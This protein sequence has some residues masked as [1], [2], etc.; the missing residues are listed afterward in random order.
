MIE[1]SFVN[2][3]IV[4]FDMNTHL[5]PD[6][7][8]KDGHNESYTR[9]IL[10]AAIS[11]CIFYTSFLASHIFSP[12]LRICQRQIFEVK[13]PLYQCQINMKMLDPGNI[14][15][16]DFQPWMIQ[17]DLLEREKLDRFTK[18]F[19]LTFQFNPWPWFPLSLKNFDILQS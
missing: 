10:H 19:F 17:E 9:Q 6:R 12:L 16:K 8:C 1:R 11:W 2:L 18:N 5:N 7:I 14:I 3:K 4:I 13:D 15:K